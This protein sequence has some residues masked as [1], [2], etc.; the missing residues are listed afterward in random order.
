MFKSYLKVALRN[1]FKFKRYSFI[2]IAGLAVGM[3]CCLLILLFVKDEMSY[4]AYNKSADRIF[5]VAVFSRF[6]GQESD[7]TT[8][9]PSMISVLIKEY[10]EVEAAVRFRQVGSTTVRSGEN[11][12]QERRLIYADP[13]LFDVFTIPLLQGDPKT[14]LADPNTIVISESTARRYF[15]KV[16]PEGMIL[17]LENAADYRITG[18]FRDNPSAS[19]FH[20]DLIASLS[21]LEES[22]EV[23]WLH[24][25]FHTY[26]LLREK[27]D[28]KS[29]EAKFPALIKK[30]VG[31]EIA[32][33]TKQSYDS[34]LA[35]GVFKLSYSLQPLRRI[36]LTSKTVTE[37]EPNGDYGTIYIFS[38]IA[39]FVLFIAGFNFI[40]LSTARSVGRTREAGLR[41]VLG[42][43]RRQ[44]VRQFLV[45]STVM[46]LIAMFLA[47]VLGSLALPF[48]N[49]LA[50]KDMDLLRTGGWFLAGSTLAVALLTGLLAGIYPA[51]RISGAKPVLVLKGRLA[52]GAKS[53]WLRGALVMLQFSIS[54]VLLIGTAVVGKQLRYIQ[55]KNLGYVKEQVLVLNNAYLL[56]PQTEAFKEEMLKHPRVSSASVSNF[57]P[58]PSARTIMTI[59]P[60][61]QVVD[62][63]TASMQKWDVDFGYIRTLGMKITAGRDF[64]R[65]FSTDGS[66][67]IINRV[68]AR[69][70]GWGDPIGKELSVPDGVK[71]ADYRVI[72][73]V[74]DFHY[75][76]LKSAIGPLVM[77]LG[78]SPGAIS[79][80]IETG[81]AA[82]TVDLLRNTWS[83]FAPG[84]P[85]E[86]SFLDDRFAAVYRSERRLGL[87]FRIFA[88][89]AIFIAC[90][91]LLGLSS[92]LAEQRTKEIGIRKV[93]GASGPEIVGLLSR[94][95]TKWVLAA[96]LI[97]WPVA[98][99][100]M[101]RWLRGFAYRAEIGVGIFLLSGLLALLIALLTVSYQ[102]IRA[103][104]ANP[105]ESLRYE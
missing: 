80:R 71:T 24:Y 38:A 6:G 8:V 12:F 3:A 4:D 50:G 32:A 16:N 10:P 68:A 89:L 82:E 92:Y 48:F 83:R 73:V 46:S 84:Q 54:L 100:V 55:N 35:T 81:R 59:F 60:K 34:I 86:Y 39:L 31:P 75:D 104:L 19:H 40:N 33:F 105:V 9:P 102:A 65:D 94:E 101:Q 41:K 25:N 42:S 52:L 49:N 64:S 90:L 20:F 13:S 27:A 26:V 58:V 18:V 74:E 1:L 97:A 91:G 30:Y 44:L 62:K 43:V 95:F 69:H 79:F 98:Y 14:A 96:N 66:A 57:L 72:G 28:S 7:Y 103:A 47:I 77:V 15:R 23:R 21:S 70:F 2:N 85:L 29:L 56:G 17:R 88:G 76:S 87:I 5:R 11:G 51:L 22:R 53:G 37:L 45:E 99:F 67:A 93:I 36:H 78:N 61:G 63:R